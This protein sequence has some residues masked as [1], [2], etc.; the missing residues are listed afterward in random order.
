M[1]FSYYHWGPWLQKPDGNWPHGYIT[2]SGLPMKFVRTDGTLTSVY[3]Q[4]TETPNGQLFTGQGGHEGVSAAQAFAISQGL[5]DASLA[6][7]WLFGM[8]PPGDPKIA[9]TMQAIEQQLWVK[10]SVGGVARYTGD[11]YHQVSQDLSNV[12]GNP[13]FICTLWLARWKIAKARSFKDLQEGMDIISWTIRHSQPA[14]A[15]A[16]QIDPGTG[17]PVSVSPLPWSHAEFVIAVHEYLRKHAELASA[18]NGR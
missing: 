11:Q 3:Q 1:D 18:A 10:T 7:L 2:G 8:Y 13:W 15:L 9:S 12:P 5:I 16:E 17:A 4:L 14:G 6:G